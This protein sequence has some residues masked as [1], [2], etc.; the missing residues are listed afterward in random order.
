MTMTGDMCGLKA[1]NPFASDVTKQSNA[2]AL[3]VWALPPIVTPL[4]TK[5]ARLLTG[6]VGTV[7][8]AMPHLQ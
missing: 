2:L 3:T 1:S 4:S 5:V 7:Q 6:C 8:R